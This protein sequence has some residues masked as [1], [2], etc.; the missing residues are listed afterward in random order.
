MLVSSDEIHHRNNLGT[1]K[2]VDFI[3]IGAQKAGTSWL[4]RRLEE[5]PEFSLPPIKELHYFDRNRK[6]DSPHTLAHSNLLL[7]LCNFWWLK[8][9]NRRLLK[10]I[11]QDDKKHLNWYFNYFFSNYN[12][13]FYLNLFEGLNGIKGEVSPSYSMLEIDDIQNIHELLPQL[14]LVL[15]LRDPIDRAWSHYNYI[16]PKDKILDLAHFKSFINAPKQEKRSNY[17]EIINNYTSVFPKEQLFIGFYDQI[18]VQPQQLLEN[19]VSF[20]GGDARQVA[21]YCQLDKRNN[22]NK[23]KAEIPGHYLEELKMKYEPIIR[24]LS[25]SLNGYACQ[26]QDLYF[27]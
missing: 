16:N 8:N 5:L 24:E 11:F 15:L 17:I 13:S 12:D 9:L 21:K 6:Y 18:K 22:V 20:L 3:G 2:T 19:V 23:D 27:E 7:K 4:F 10:N 26:W 14:N 25:A 1:N